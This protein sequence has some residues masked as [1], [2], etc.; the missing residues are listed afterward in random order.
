MKRKAIKWLFLALAVLGAMALVIKIAPGKTWFLVNWS[1]FGVVMLVVAF[2]LR[3]GLK[4]KK[5]ERKKWIFQIVNP[6][7][8]GAPALMFVATLGL[9]N[10]PVSWILRNILVSAFVYGSALYY[11]GS[12]YWI[13]KD[14][15]AARVQQI[16]TGKGK[17]KK[18]IKKGV[19]LEAPSVDF[20]PFW[21]YEVLRAKSDT[22]TKELILGALSKE[23]K[24]GKSLSRTLLAKI[25]FSFSYRI[26]SLVASVGKFKI[27]DLDQLVKEE[28]VTSFRAVLRKKTIEG[29]LDKQDEIGKDTLEKL[30]ARGKL[31]E[32]DIEAETANLL[33]VSV[34]NALHRA[35]NEL[36]LM[37]MENEEVYEK[38]KVGEKINTGW[39]TKEG[40]RE[41]RDFVIKNR[42]I[43]KITSEG[44]TDQK[45]EVVKE[46]KLEMVNGPGRAKRGIHLVL[47]GLVIVANLWLGFQI[48][49]SVIENARAAQK[50]AVESTIVVP[51]A[52][53]SGP[54]GTISPPWE[55]IR[56]P[57]FSENPIFW[58][59]FAFLMAF[60]VYAAAA[61]ISKKEPE[62]LKEHTRKIVGIC[63]VM[64]F[65]NI[66]ALAYLPRA[67]PGMIVMI[68]SLIFGARISGMRTLGALAGMMMVLFVFLFIVKFM[69]PTTCYIF[70]GKFYAEQ[71]HSGKLWEDTKKGIK[72]MLDKPKTQASQPVVEPK[73]KT[74]KKVTE[75]YRPKAEETKQVRQVTPK[76]ET[77]VVE[78]ASVVKE[79]KEVSNIS[80]G[81]FCSVITN[82][83]EDYSDRHTGEWPRDITDGSLAYEPVSS[84]REDGCIAW[85]NMDRGQLLTVTVTIDLKGTYN[86]TKIRYN[87]G[88]CQRANAWNA[89][90]ME[91]PFGRIPTNPGSS[92]QGTW[93]EQTGSI[94][95]SIVTVRFEKSPKRG[96]W[97]FIGEI[98]IWGTPVE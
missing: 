53:P 36:S 85:K 9:A 24:D 10:N 3:R 19:D 11:L 90:I 47:V 84:G 81:K 69:I 32:W 78:K 2:S 12:T 89:D 58:G 67:G 5:W 22:V 43:A 17:R 4:E 88:D 44:D 29:N 87:P 66:F 25:R 68:L 64:F 95:A 34:D 37:D 13:Y 1:I 40:K 39:T 28:F 16:K 35:Q 97:L 71:I 49:P 82:G 20:W 61:A 41:I 52:N 50:P 30:E 74:P 70:D 7:A 15:V 94:T 38:I 96:S 63:V 54:S 56:I 42:R 23:A 8:L 60:L 31:A 72:D 27:E 59:A 83:V 55:N 80:L 18:K 75:F 6:I 98:E 45:E 57:S 77:R 76:H 93:T 51:P 62:W 33:D 48:L 73:A 26:R 79:V 14:E 46:Q 86:I 92:Y 91:S 65:F 21:A